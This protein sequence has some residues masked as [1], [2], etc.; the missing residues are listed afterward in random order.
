MINADTLSFLAD[1]AANNHKEWFDANRSRYQ[2]AKDNVLALVGSTLAELG[3]AEGWPLVDPK[4][5]IFRQNR[6]VRFSKDK[7][8]YKTNMA[9]IAGPNGM[10]GDVLSGIYVHLEPGQSFLGMGLYEPSGD[11]LKKVR[12]EIDFNLDKWTGIAQAPGFVAAF[13]GVTGDKLKTAPKG[14]KADHPAIEWLRHT[15]YLAIQKLTDSQL[16]QKSLPKTIAAA[17]TAAAPFRQF[18]LEALA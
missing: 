1:L 9:F 2:L 5:C 7:R 10:K 17:F 12:Q 15:Q 13:G 18:L 4:Q 3:P 6:D 16:Q 14:Y 11:E 8:P